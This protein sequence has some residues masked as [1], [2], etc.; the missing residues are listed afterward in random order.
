MQENISSEDKRIITS[1]KKLISLMQ[2]GFS[3]FFISF[4]VYVP[5]MLFSIKP[6][7]DEQRF[8][9]FLI[10]LMCF[11][12]AFGIFFGLH[13]L[14]VNRLNL[15]IKSSKKR[16]YDAIVENSRGVR[17]YFKNPEGQM[18]TVKVGGMLGYSKGT[19]IR[20]HES[21]A[22]EYIYKVEKM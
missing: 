19:K 21:L 6:P 5:Y 12:F 22:G 13:F 11:A 14:F 4:G 18:R 3:L 16:V 15:A 2:W 20:V 10:S 17:I 7:T 1:K 8:F 9:I